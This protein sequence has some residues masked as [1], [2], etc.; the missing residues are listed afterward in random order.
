MPFKSKK[1]W[2][3]FF[4]MAGRGEIPESKAEEW[5]H[6]TKTPY[7][8]LPTKKA[9]LLKMAAEIGRLRAHSEAGL[10]KEASKLLPLGIGLGVGALAGA[11]ATN[12]L[13]AKHKTQEITDQLRG[14]MATL[15]NSVLAELMMR[16][17]S[18]EMVSH[19]LSL[20]SQRMQ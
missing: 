9:Q 17:M 12:A 2:K 8:K 13:A 10:H 15:P 18:P 3:K 16:G 1:Q 7:S 14:Q 6:E 4:A 19:V 5:A 20:Q 11:I